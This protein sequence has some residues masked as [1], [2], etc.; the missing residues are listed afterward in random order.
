[1]ADVATRL[2]TFLL[3][4]SSIAAAVGPRVHQS[5]VP[6]DTPTPCIYFNRESTSDELTIG[7]IGAAA[8]SHTFAVE[9]IGKDFDDSIE[10][11]GLVRTRCNGY[12]GSFADTTVKGIFIDSQSE[13]YEPQYGYLDA[14]LSLEVVP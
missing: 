14:S 2:R 12:Y 3:A 11:A 13:D 9:C 10:L 7:E 8:F 5:F 1:L 6:E 4:D